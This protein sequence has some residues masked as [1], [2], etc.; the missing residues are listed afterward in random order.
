MS[1]FNGRQRCSVMNPAELIG[2]DLY[3]KVPEIERI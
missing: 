2:R 1:H 3:P